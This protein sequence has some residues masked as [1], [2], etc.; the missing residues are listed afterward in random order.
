MNIS[1]Y[2]SFLERVQSHLDTQSQFDKGMLTFNS[3]RRV[4]KALNCKHNPHRYSHSPYPCGIC[5]VCRGNQVYKQFQRISSNTFDPLIHDYYS[6]GLSLPRWPD[7]IPVIDG[8]RNFGELLFTTPTLFQPS[9]DI[10]L[11]SILSGIRT[12][13]REAIQ[14]CF[15]GMKLGMFFGLH[16]VNDYMMFSPHIHSVLCGTAIDESYWPLEMDVKGRFPELGQAW[17]TILGGRHSL[18][19]R[20][21]QKMLLINWADRLSEYLAQVFLQYKAGFIQ[22]G[23]FPTANTAFNTFARMTQ[24][25]IE[26][27]K[28]IIRQAVVSDPACVYLKKVDMDLKA[29][30]FSPAKAYKKVI[31]YAVTRPF[32]HTEFRELGAGMVSANVIEDGKKKYIGDFPTLVRR[33]LQYFSIYG[34]R[35]FQAYGLFHPGM[36]RV[37]HQAFIKAMNGGYPRVKKSVSEA[38][39]RRQAS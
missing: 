35:R 29:Q 22:P 39:R 20:N 33:M 37:R 15:P 16:V 38:N 8:C 26:A 27:L 12:V 6:I 18:S 34:V 1:T 36:G 5:E 10:P 25:D 3:L 28:P 13:G 14:D 21:V 2:Y 17:R 7:E 11:H 23:T 9:K 30:K 4:V 24:E 32:K 19:V 31:E